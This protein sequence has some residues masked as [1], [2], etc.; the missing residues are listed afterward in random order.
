MRPSPSSPG[1]R[2]PPLPRD[3]GA[4]ATGQQAPAEPAAQQR[5][6]WQHPKPL[7]LLAGGCALSASSV[8]I[9]QGIDTLATANP[10]SGLLPR[11]MLPS[12]VGLR[13]QVTGGCGADAQSTRFRHAW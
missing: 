2:R 8:W 11:S 1:P 10:A 3:T 9:R 7:I 5:D 13:H 4:D 6:S 12:R